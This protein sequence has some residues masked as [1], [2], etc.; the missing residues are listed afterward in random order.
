MCMYQYFTG[1]RYDCGYFAP[2]MRPV[3]VI[4]LG[5][6]WWRRRRS[7]G[8]VWWP[9]TKASS[10]TA[11]RPRPI[12]GNRPCDLFGPGN[13]KITVLNTASSCEQHL[14]C[15]LA[16]PPRVIGLDCEWGGARD[17][18]VALLQ[19]AFPNNECVLVHLSEVGSVVPKLAEILSDRR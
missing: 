8:P 17:L 4:V 10:P 18:P 19:L 12:E 5:L 6:G 2:T 3:G 15:C 9:L 14:A 13:F 1:L 7:P 16:T 11:R